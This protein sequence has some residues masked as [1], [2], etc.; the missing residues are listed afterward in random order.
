MQ[1][2]RTI[3]WVVLLIALLLFSLNNWE[4]VT[5]KIW[6]DLVWETKLP[7]VVLISFLLGWLPTWLVLLAG[8]WRMNRRINSLE[9][10]VRQPSAS[11]SSTRLE[12]A[13]DPVDPPETVVR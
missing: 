7:V 8:K 9:A 13:A 11:L 3:V 6:E 10:V 5:V 4:T 2:I 12:E 1:I